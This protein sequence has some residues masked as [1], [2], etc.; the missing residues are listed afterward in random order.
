MSADDLVIA[1]GFVPFSAID[2]PG[3]LSAVVF[4]QGCPWNC[5]YCQNP[6]LIDMKAPGETSW[7]DVRTTLEQRVGLLDGLVFSGGEP[8]R[9]R[10]LLDA[11]L[12]LKELGF[13]AALHTSGAYPDRLKA[14][15]PH[16]A[17]LGLDIKASPSRYAEVTRR[18]GSGEK[19]W[20][21]LDLVVA[22]GVDYEVRV[23]VDPTIMTL[24]DVEEIVAEID[25]RG[26]RP[27]VLQ[28]VRAEG[29]RPAFV[30]RLGDLRLA[31]VVPTEALPGI[32][33]RVEL[34]SEASPGIREAVSRRESTE[35]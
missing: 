2:W 24:A 12:E 26:S 3:K 32:E 1:G 33:R 11:V 16:V 28:E 9:Q 10:A 34:P 25:R 4:L 18:A 23:T 13:G 27:P 8:T 14:L 29:A 22:S 20:A 5:G 30:E 21:S 15:L 17:W 7:A 19:A 6:D 35:F 31:D